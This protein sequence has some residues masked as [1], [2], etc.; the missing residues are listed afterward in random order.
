MAKIKHKGCSIYCS[1]EKI[2]LPSPPLTVNVYGKNNT[3][4]GQRRNRPFD[5][6]GIYPQ[7]GYLRAFLQ[8]GI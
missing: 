3:F 8:A 2:L 6:L 7:S 4:T 5:R 1:G